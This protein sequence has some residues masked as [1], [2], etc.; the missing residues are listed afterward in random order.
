MELKN[1]LDV[2]Y[3]EDVED[4]HDAS[5]AAEALRKREK[6]LVR[7]LDLFIAPV[8]K[9]MGITFHDCLR[10]T[11]TLIPIALQVM[12]MLMLISYL[13]RGVCITTTRLSNEHVLTARCTEHR[14][15]G[16][17]GYDQRYRPEGSSVQRA[18]H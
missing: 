6:A 10:R 17:A 14:L 7:K 12:M 9:S 18:F 11:L 1:K 13:D 4:V 2:S 15:R 3:Q 16:Y 8:S 5:P